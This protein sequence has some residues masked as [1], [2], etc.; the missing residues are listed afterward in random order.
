VDLGTLDLLAQRTICHYGDPSIPA[1]TV[2]APSIPAEGIQGFSHF[3]HPVFLQAGNAS[4]LYGAVERSISCLSAENI[5]ELASEVPLV[6]FRSART[7]ALSKAGRR[8]KR[9]HSS[10]PMFSAWTERAARR[11]QFYG[12]QAH[13]SFLIVLHEFPE[14]NRKHACGMHHEYGC[15]AGLDR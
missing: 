7:R 12:S 15:W 13:T 10:L 3:S 5:D 6:C 11:A 4:C 8:Q 1:P 9:L 2:L 14:H